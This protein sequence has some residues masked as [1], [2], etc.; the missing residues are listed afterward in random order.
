[1]SVILI[2]TTVADAH[3][4]CVAIVLGHMGHRPVLWHC[5]DMP[6]RAAASVQLGP[7]ETVVTTLHGREIGVD[8]QDVDVF[9]NRRVGAPV[10]ETD[11]LDCDRR[12]AEQ[13]SERFT[14]SLLA[15]AS[16]DA[17]A[18]N[19]FQAARHAEDKVVQL[20]TAR[21]LGMA[22]PPTLISNAPER[23]RRFVGALEEKGV[24][25][26]NF[27]P[28]AWTGVAPGPLAMNFTAKV[29]GGTLP[30][31]GIL[32]LTPAIYQALVPKDHEVRVT[33]MGAELVA[34]ALQTQQLEYSRVDWRRAPN[35]SLAM[36][37][38]ELPAAVADQCR[39]L[40]AQLN[41]R[42][43]C[44]DFIVTPDGDWVFLEVNQM[45]QFLWIEQANGE[46]PMLQT[47]CDFLVSKDPGFRCTRRH[48][49]RTFADVEAEAL[50][51]LSI[52]TKSHLRPGIAPHVYR[53]TCGDG[54]EAS[55]SIAA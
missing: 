6:E 21:G 2:P 9:W 50:Q 5:S 26:K 48:G 43:G 18:V 14:R 17:F 39:Q 15:L 30:R 51:R 31:D 47:F 8:F 20:V 33:C 34:V 28:M 12:I 7:Q 53:E 49:G 54:R 27:S 55:L 29:D 38:T 35:A 37:R 42:F 23:I 4:H 36:Q 41:L 52:A 16:R 11:L 24:V 44:F 22:L 25:V 19:T 13:E 1:M 46:I 32:R 10:V 40:M 3:A 45:G